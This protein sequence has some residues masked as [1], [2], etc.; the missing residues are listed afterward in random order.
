V[1]L[2]QQWVLKPYGEL[3]LFTQDVDELSA[4]RGFSNTEIGLQL[5]YEVTRKFAPYLDLRHERNF[6]DDKDGDTIISAGLRL[7]F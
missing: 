3:N 5:R 2:T 6:G 1:L 7:M 4:D